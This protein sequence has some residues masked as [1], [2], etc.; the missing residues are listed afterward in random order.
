MRLDV[1]AGLFPCDTPARR[2]T[3]EDS[4]RHRTRLGIPI[5]VLAQQQQPYV[6]S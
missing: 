2:I 1:R 6:R 5:S 4:R 3:V